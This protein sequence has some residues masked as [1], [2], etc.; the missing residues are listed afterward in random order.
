[1]ANMVDGEVWHWVLGGGCRSRTIFILR[2]TVKATKA[3]TWSHSSALFSI[4]GTKLSGVRGCSPS[5]VGWSSRPPSTVE[6]PDTQTGCASH[7]HLALFY[8]S[9]C[10][11]GFQLPSCEIGSGKIITNFTNLKKILRKSE[12]LKMLH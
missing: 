6:M 7:H 2:R 1:M 10:I 9:W 4:I 8:R 3:A 12:F 5:F 11:Q